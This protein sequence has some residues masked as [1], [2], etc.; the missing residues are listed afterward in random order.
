MVRSA[1]ASTLRILEGED[2]EWGAWIESTPHDI[3]HTAAYHRVATFDGD[4]FPQ[5]LIYGA[6]DRFVAWPYLLNP[7]LDTAGVLDRPAFDVSSTYGYS[8]P[9][10]HGCEP[11]DPIISDAFEAF[12]SV[13]LEQGV[14][15]AFTRFHPI[16]Q[17]H[18]WFLGVLDPLVPQHPNQGVLL[19][20]T[21]VSID[22]TKPDSQVLA[23]YPRVF[24]QEI[25]SSRRKGLLTSIDRELAY[26]ETF[27]ELYADT[28]RRNNAQR[29]YF[30]RRDYF[31][32]LIAALGDDAILFVTK[33]GSDVAG[34]CLFLSHH[35]ILHPHL[36]GTS[37]PFLP[38]S[39][40]KVMW[41]DV[42]R[43]AAERGDRVMHLGGGRGGLSDSLLAFKSRFSP[44][45]RS[46]YTGRWI[47]DHARYER[48][49]QQASIDSD[50]ESDY[51]PIYRAPRSLE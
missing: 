32:D 21:T 3:Y 11:G 12:R 5:L 7:I 50:A 1:R 15:S 42:R 29:A 36:A 46:F 13:W 37:T 6:A 47:L 35:G 41:D 38:M 49:A 24:R 19:T 39:P 17:N 34:A 22:L 8:G 48:L 45:R 27:T 14:I 33:S 26:L 44:D 25:A 16:L 20:G 30:L 9:L 4:G 28:M 40:L 2:P 31:P 18:R 51:F 10:A 43:W 23:E